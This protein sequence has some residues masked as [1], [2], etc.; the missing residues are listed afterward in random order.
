MIAAS[1]RVGFALGVSLETDIFG[2]PLYSMPT[3]HGGRKAEHLGPCVALFEKGCA[4]LVA[5]QLLWDARCQIFAVLHLFVDS[6]AQATRRLV[7]PQGECGEETG[8][9]LLS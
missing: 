8:L 4:V 9:P 3:Y 1:S 7:E 6:L 5:I 2:S